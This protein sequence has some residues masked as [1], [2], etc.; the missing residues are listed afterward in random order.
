MPTTTFTSSGTFTVPSN[1]GSVNVLVVA[2]G[3]GGG[4]NCGGGGGAGGVVTNSSFAVTPGAN[5]TVVVGSGG[6]GGTNINGYNGGNGGNSSFSSI[7]ALGGGGGG[8]YA[9]ATALPAGGSGGGGT[10]GS[11][12]LGGSGTAGQGYAGG[13]G[14]NGNGGSGPYTTGGGGGAGG[15]GR[16][17]TSTL[18]GNGGSG[19]TYSG[20]LYAAGGGGGAGTGGSGGSAGGSGAGNGG[21]Q[22]GTAATSAA[23]NTGSGGGGGAGGGQN[24]SNGG[25]GIVIVSWASFVTGPSSS[26]AN[27]V[28]L[29]ADASGTVIKDGGPLGSSGYLNEYNVNASAYGASPSTGASANVT[30]INLAITALNAAGGGRL[31]FPGAGTYN[32]N[33]ALTSISVPCEIVGMG[34]GVTTIAQSSSST[35]VFTITAT[36]PVWIHGLNIQGGGTSGTGAGIQLGTS[37]T[38]NSASIIEDCEISNCYVG[39]YGPYVVNGPTISNNTIG[40]NQYGIIIGQSY[41]LNGS[42]NYSLLGGT[43]TIEGNILNNVVSIL[44]T[45]SNGNLIIGNYIDGGHYAFQLNDPLHPMTTMTG[46]LDTWIVGN[47]IEDFSV[48]ALLFTPPSASGV[49]QQY[50]N[51]VIVGNEFANGAST[52]GPQLATSTSSV[53]GVWLQRFVITGNVFQDNSGQHAISLYYAEFSTITGNAFGLLGAVAGVYIDSSC[54]NVI[55]DPTSNSFGFGS[56]FITDN[57]AHT[58]ANLQGASS[59]KGARTYVT[60]ATSTTFASIVAGGGGNTVPIFSDGSNWRIG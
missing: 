47:H 12:Q 9:A 26:T 22:G 37:S 20:T 1:V 15:V 40:G 32:I 33:A 54:N 8:A 51:I 52:T 42:Y 10:G 14:D 59:A 36:N 16:D 55:C 11:G 46:Y 6:A 5:I 7:S 17:A 50:A 18:S 35:N 30:A 29:F 53:N 25:S 24:G 44:Q 28:A 48:S 23:A 60:D 57:Q 19:Y 41:V 38:A 27:N 13:Q 3:G 43:S 2:G 49:A 45:N 56:V 34:L 31:L 21:T 4:F 58:V 39:I